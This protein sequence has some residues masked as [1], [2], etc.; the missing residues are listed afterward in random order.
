MNETNF[1][2]S[3]AKGKYEMP[4]MLEPLRGKACGKSYLVGGVGAGI[5][6]WL[7][8]NFQS[9]I[10]ADEVAPLSIHRGQRPFVLLVESN[11]SNTDTLL[12]IILDQPGFVL[13]SF[14]RR[15]HVRGRNGDLVRRRGCILKAQESHVLPN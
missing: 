6:V 4:D 12:A 13:A 14:R 7:S 9:S 11:D 8:G 1:F 5:G 3:R 2:R 10:P 15:L